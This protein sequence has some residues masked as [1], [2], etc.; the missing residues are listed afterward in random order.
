MTATVPAGALAGA[1]AP[2]MIDKGRSRVNAYM[3]AVT[4]RNAITD[5]AKITIIMPEPI[6]FKEDKLSSE[7][8]VK[9]TKP[10]AISDRNDSCRMECSSKIFRTDGPRIAPKII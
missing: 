9:A 8:M 4:V 3:A 10:S 1:M 2:K 7:P 5:S 6:R